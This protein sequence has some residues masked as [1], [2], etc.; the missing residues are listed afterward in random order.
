MYRVVVSLILC[1]MIPNIGAAQEIPSA[2]LQQVHNLC[3]NVG[4]QSSAILAKLYCYNTGVQA[5]LDKKSL[6]QTLTAAC[7]SAVRWTQTSRKSDV[8][9]WCDRQILNILSQ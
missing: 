3:A 1:L 5:L 7:D 2:S 8:K 6:R 4:V 9:S